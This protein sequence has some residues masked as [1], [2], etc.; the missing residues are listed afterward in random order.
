MILPNKAGRH[1]SRR[2]QL[3]HRIVRSEIAKSLDRRTRLDRKVGLD[4][5]RKSLQIQLQQ[6]RFLAV[7]DGMHV[8]VL[9][10][11]SLLERDFSRGFHVAHPLRAPARRDQ[12]ALAPGPRQPHDE[13]V[14]GR[15]VD[16]SRFAAAHF[17]KVIVLQPQAESNK[18]SERPVEELFNQVQLSERR[19][20]RVS[21]RVRILLSSAR[22][23]KQRIATNSCTSRLQT[24]P[25]SLA[26][27]QQNLY[28]HSFMRDLTPE[29]LVNG[30]VWYVAFLFSTTCH[31]ASH[32]L[33]AK[34]GGDETAALGG[35]V[36]LNPIPHIRREP[37]GMV[38]IPLLAFFVSGSMI[39]WA[40]APY[41]PLWERRHPRRAAWMALAGPTANYSLMLLA[42][43]GIR[44][45]AAMHWLHLSAAGTGYDLPTTALM[46]FFF[47][48]LLLGT[49]NLLP[50]PPLDGSTGIMLFMNEN[51]AQ[52]YLDWLRGN[53][54]AM[55][56][57]LVALLVFRSFYR[58]VESFATN[59]FLRGHF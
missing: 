1:F 34:L 42:A 10:G 9:A 57:L 25:T 3:E 16:A 31:E 30:F 17:Q 23:E 4:C 44:V 12:V 56:G 28:P 59:L 43:L 45:G 6:F 47:L 36:S 2:S 15:G 51:R 18:E 13:Q 48:N 46:A 21:T 53:S 32:A 11:S 41:D 8:E 50:V 54:Y 5:R 58:Y 19:S 40:S 52:R 55:L 20:I 49:F 39:G 37:F 29:M 22:R 26:N 7:G 27:H 38:L 35:Q 24:A 33:V 14:D